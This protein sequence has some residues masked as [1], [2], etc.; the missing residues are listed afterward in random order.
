VVYAISFGSVQQHVSFIP[1]AQF[2]PFS[3]LVKYRLFPAPAYFDEAAVVPPQ[4]RHVKI[5]TRETAIYRDFPC[6]PLDG[7]KVYKEVGPLPFP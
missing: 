2:L 1:A 4:Y 3:G 5:I 6:S 7:K